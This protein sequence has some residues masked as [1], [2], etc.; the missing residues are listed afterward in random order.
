MARALC[1]I[2]TAE[3]PAP[4]ALRSSAFAAPAKQGSE[5]EEGDR[6]PFAKAS[7]G[8]PKYQ[9]AN[10][11]GCFVENDNYLHIISAKLTVLLKHAICL[12]NMHRV[13]PVK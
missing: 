1:K 10:V 2:A 4:L 3:S 12:T 11:P 7:E 9:I 8:R 5:G 6:P 13:S